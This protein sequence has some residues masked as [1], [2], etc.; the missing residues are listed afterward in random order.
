[1]NMVIIVRRLQNNGIRIPDHWLTV[2]HRQISLCQ[3]VSQTVY[4]SPM[5]VKKQNKHNNGKGHR[6]LNINISIVFGKKTV[7]SRP[8][9]YLC[10]TSVSHSTALVSLTCTAS[11]LQLSGAPRGRSDATCP[12][13]PLPTPL[14]PSTAR[15]RKWVQRCG[16]SRTDTTPASER[17]EHSG[18]ARTSATRPDDVRGLERGSLDCAV[19]KR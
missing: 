8:Q 6:S 16:F 7:A 12:P 17:R 19:A 5:S 2:L 1:M 13:Q 9:F 18:S 14:H 3:S 4:H 11:P 10:C 15:Y